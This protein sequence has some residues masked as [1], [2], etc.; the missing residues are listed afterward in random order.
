MSMKD[1]LSQ[2]EVDALLEGLESGD[3]ETDGPSTHSEVVPYDLGNSNNPLSGTPRTLNKIYESFVIDFRKQLTELLHHPVEV[4]IE[5]TDRIEY[6]EYMED[7]RSLGSFNVVTASSLNGQGVVVLTTELVAIIVDIFFGGD[8]VHALPI[9]GR[10]FTRAENRII[11][12]VLERT[13]SCLSNAWAP[14]LRTSFKY[15]RA[16][17]YLEFVDIASP[18]EVVFSTRFRI[19]LEGG[20]GEFHITMPYSMLELVKRELSDRRPSTVT[21]NKDWSKE[22]QYAVQEMGVELVGNL[23]ETELTLGE[24]INLKQGDV[25]TVRI[26]EQVSLQVNRRPLFL[27]IYGQNKGRNAVRVTHRLS[28]NNALSTSQFRKAGNYLQ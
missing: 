23:V 5:G 7:M 1:V 12:L 24:I 6:K 19:T 10:D 3:L 2:E 17:K 27:G 4:V 15:E 21:V 16:E 13:F 20:G 28:G 9:V 8:G 18:E 22:L 25:I 14:V 11:Q 26:P